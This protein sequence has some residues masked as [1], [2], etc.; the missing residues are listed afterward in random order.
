MRFPYRAARRTADQSACLTRRAMLINRIGQ[1]N[2]GFARA[3]SS[4]HIAARQPKPQKARSSDASDGG[5]PSA[6][7]L[8]TQQAAADICAFDALATFIKP[9][10]F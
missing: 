6:R 8:A 7:R 5:P 4:D 10:L 2:S 3:R 9:T 1:C